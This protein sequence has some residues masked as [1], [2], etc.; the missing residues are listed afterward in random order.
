MCENLEFIAIIMYKKPIS[1]SNFLVSL[2]LN[3]IIPLCPCECSLLI[4]AV[5]IGNRHR[6]IDEKSPLFN[7][8]NTRYKC[9]QLSSSV[10]MVRDFCVI[11]V[12]KYILKKIVILD[13][14]AFYDLFMNQTEKCTWTVKEQSLKQILFPI[15]YWREVY[16]I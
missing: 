1:I 11:K 12:D 8:K 5:H 6:V 9:T 2:S 15:L 14:F 3:Y 10:K 4:V 13:I 7:C 16:Q